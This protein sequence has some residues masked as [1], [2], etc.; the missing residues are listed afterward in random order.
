M[1]NKAIRFLAE[2]GLRVNDLDR[3]SAFYRDLVGLEV[4]DEGE[5]YVFF[6]VAEAVDG[7]PQL[8]VLFDRDSKVNQTTTTL[9]HMAFLI[10]VDD[11][12]AQRRR[13]EGFGVEVFA[14]EFPDFHWRSLFFTDPEGNR[15]EFVAYDPS[16]RNHP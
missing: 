1:P 2:V 16:V 3:M 8:I 10:D 15:V 7:H 5:G 4:F 12:D 14:K 11:Y 13:L 9:D 6:R